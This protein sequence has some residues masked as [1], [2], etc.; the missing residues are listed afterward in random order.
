VK[1]Q[2]S[3]FTSKFFDC[4]NIKNIIDNE[5]KKLE[6]NQP[7]QNDTIRIVFLGRGHHINKG[8]F[9]GSLERAQ[10]AIQA[11]V[12]EAVEMVLTYLKDGNNFE[13]LVNEHAIRNLISSFDA[14]DIPQMLELFEIDESTL[15]NQLGMK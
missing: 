13:N 1:N 14:M 6:Q 4:N 3:T 5:I 15:T 10:K 9:V 8:A 11:S 2:I 12:D 7:P